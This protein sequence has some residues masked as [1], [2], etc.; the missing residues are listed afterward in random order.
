MKVLAVLVLVLALSQ[1]AVLPQFKGWLPRSVLYPRAPV[2]Q[3]R[4]YQVPAKMV[5]DHDTK[6]ICGNGAVAD[7]KIVGGVE[8]VPGE[9]PWQVAVR[10]DGMYFCGGSLIDSTH[11]LTA[12]HCTDGAQ[13]FRLTF[14]A[15]DISTTEPTQV[16]VD[17][18]RYTIHP[19]W[20]PNTLAGDMSIIILDT[21]VTYTARIAPICLIGS[22]APDY[23]GA[24]LTVSGWGK[25]SDAATGISPV[26]RKV[27]VQGITRTQCRL[28][29]IGLG[30]SDDILCVATTGGK[31]S[32]NGDSGGP[33]SF[34]QAD[35]TFNQVGV[36]S[37]GSSRGC[38]VGVPAGFSRVSSY[39]QWLTDNTGLII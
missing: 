2:A 19:N 33:L 30:I 6:A 5:P 12:A 4:G 26:L 39:T 13:S 24:D 34:I 22:N 16:T 37:F 38:E 1:A 17:A 14:G 8:A 15:H 28:S 21:P 31:G 20:D 35:G 36:V 25:P 3:G 32:C 10:I 18:T 29:Y 23:V 9:F 7:N 27:V 11:V